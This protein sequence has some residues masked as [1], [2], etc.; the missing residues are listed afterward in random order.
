MLREVIDFVDDVEQ[1]LG[2][3]FV[4]FDALGG[5]VGN[6]YQSLVVGRLE[7]HHGG[8][9]AV[10]GALLEVVDERR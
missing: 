5:F 1:G 2:T 7:H 9:E 3:G 4:I 6:F 10:F 8:A